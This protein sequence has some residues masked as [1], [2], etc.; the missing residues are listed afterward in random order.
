MSFVSKER[1]GQKESKKGNSIS[2]YPLKEV[3]IWLGHYLFGPS[4]NN[5]EKMVIV[6]ESYI[7]NEISPEYTLTF[8]GDIMDLDFKDLIIDESVKC[9][10]KGSDYLIGNFEGTITTENKEIMD[11]RHKPQILDALKT[12]FPP[13]KTYLSIANNHGGDFGPNHFI[14]SLNQL[15]D[16]GFNVFGTRKNPFIDINKKIRIL[17]GTQWSNHPCDYLYDL[18]EPK[19]YLKVNSFNIIYPHWGYEL[20]LDPRLTT[21]NNGKLLLDRFDVVIGQHSH[22]PQPISYYSNGSANKLIAYSLGDFCFGWD[23]KKL[24]YEMF[25]YGIA[26]RVE[27]GPN[28][29]KELQIGKINWTFLKSRPLNEKAFIVETVDSIPN[30]I[31]LRSKLPFDHMKNA[32]SALKDPNHKRNY[33]WKIFTAKNRLKY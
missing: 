16:S 20:E 27:I 28:K 13:N 21:I 33:S 12:M 25:H 11:K 5:K 24:K 2:L 14:N 3:F 4:I 19:A 9:F 31:R 18:V 30:L 7:L 1:Y 23:M 15:K 8:I 17:G 29:D 6:P 26:I 32:I 22:C 10:I